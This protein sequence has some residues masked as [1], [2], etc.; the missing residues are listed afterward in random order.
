MKKRY[1]SRL[2]ASIAFIA[3]MLLPGSCLEYSVT[4][5]VNRDGSIVR[6][7]TVRGDSSDIFKGSLRIPS[8][9]FWKITNGFEEN[10]R[11]KKASEKQ[12]FYTAS[13]KFNDV[14]EL[15]EWLA[16]DT[17]SN[18]IKIK[19]NLKK[20]FRWFYTY[21]QYT[22]LYP[23]SFPFRNV[24]VD[25]FLTEIEQSF[26][27]EDGRSVYSPAEKKWIWK[28]DALKFHYN[29]E[30][31]VEIE[32]MNESCNKK[33][34]LWITTAIVNEF[35]AIVKDHFVN[36]PRVE[37]MMQKMIQNT[38]TILN[39][40]YLVPDSTLTGNLIRI[41]DSLTG[42]TTLSELYLNDPMV[43]SSFE[44]K[45]KSL[46]ES[47]YSDE[48]EYNLS[49]P[50]Q[51]YSTNAFGRER[52]RLNWKFGPMLFFMKDF[53]MKAESRVANPWIMLVSGIVVAFLLMIL[54]SRWR[55]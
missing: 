54:V 47:D 31:S 48:Y 13:G 34:E 17:R 49:I 46:E 5:S 26:L 44:R 6:E 14:G 15:N 36:D 43:F 1:T 11:E 38:E 30:D 28:T 22:E 21:Y 37:D 2:R 50:G 27:T 52:E 24:P 3:L 42:G 20:Q 35:N 12:Y 18:T 41:G 8:G 33:M 16:T 53:E 29:H 4:T 39:K 23:M 19:V 7:Y 55:K 9:N 25:S 45:L 51:V 40:T 32:R 10:D